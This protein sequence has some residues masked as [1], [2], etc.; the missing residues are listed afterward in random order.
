MTKLELYQRRE[1]IAKA[2]LVDFWDSVESQIK[3]LGVQVSPGCINPELEK[4]LALL[5]AQAVGDHIQKN[6]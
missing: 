1:V 2:A 3:Q 4:V 6:V 5:G